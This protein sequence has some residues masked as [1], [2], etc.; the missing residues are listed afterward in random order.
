MLRSIVLGVILRFT[1]RS[2]PH[3]IG[4]PER[5]PNYVCQNVFASTVESLSP[6]EFF[7]SKMVLLQKF[8]ISV[9][10]SG[11]PP[12]HCAGPRKRV[13]QTTKVDMGEHLVLQYNQ[14]VILQGESNIARPLLADSML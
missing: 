13:P 9:R 11:L 7:S 5:C 14:P 1:E 2:I 8:D 3:I 10:L 4:Y 12:F 6:V